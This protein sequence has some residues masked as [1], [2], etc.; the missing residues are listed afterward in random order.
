MCVNRESETLSTY[1]F[2]D[3]ITHGAEGL[4]KELKAVSREIEQGASCVAILEQI[5]DGFFEMDYYLRFG[6]GRALMI[7]NKIPFKMVKRDRWTKAVGVETL[8]G[9]LEVNAKHR[10]LYVLKRKYPALRITFK[11]C[12]SLWLVEYS[13][14]VFQS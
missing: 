3:Q 6:E 14:L 1:S 8:K 5:V 4:D 12:D 11:T 7:A 2:Y 10:R 13:K 9:E